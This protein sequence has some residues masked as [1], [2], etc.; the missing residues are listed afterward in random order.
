MTKAVAPR[1][2]A[3]LLPAER[4]L[5]ALLAQGAPG[6]EEALG[7]LTEDDI[8]GLRSAE[9]LRT[10]RGLYLRAERIDAAAIAAALEGEESRRLLNEVA[11][12]APPAEV[13]NA[14]ACVRA[15]RLQP[16]EARLREIQKRLNAGTSDDELLREKTRLAQEIRQLASL[17]IP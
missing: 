15:L 3:S 10:A 16:R 5:I 2:Q 8:S 7:E 17:Q 14:L 1:A 11:V 4:W 6:I 12:A 9:L 13:L